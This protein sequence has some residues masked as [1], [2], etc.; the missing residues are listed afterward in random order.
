MRFIVQLIRRETL[1]KV[2]IIKASLVNENMGD[3]KNTIRKNVCAYCRVSTDNE[4]QQTSYASQ[5]EHYST[6]IKKNPNWNFAGIYADEGITGTQIKNRTEF[7]RMIEDAKAKKIDLII[8]KSIS[9]FARNTVDTLNT[10]RLLRSLNVDVF[11][12][13]E[14]IKTL[15]MDSEM[16]LTLYSAFAQAESESTSLNVRMGYQAKMKR[17]EACGSIKCYGYDYNKNTKILSINETEAKVV[18][19]IFDFY[20]NGLGSTRICNELMKCNIFS[21]MNAKKWHPSVIKG[22]LRNV[23][24]IGDVVGQKYFVISPITHKLVLNRG[25]RQKY[26]S[27]DHHDPI[28]DINTWNQAQNIYDKRSFAIKD[29]KQYCPKYSQRYIYSSMIECGICH[30]NYVRRVTS[31]RNKDGVKHT[32]VYWFCSAKTKREECENNI[33]VRETELNNMFI[34]LFNHLGK[35]LSIDG[36]FNKIDK[37]ISENNYESDLKQLLKEESAVNEKALKL[38]DLKL[39][40]NLDD[41]LYKIKNKELL[42]QLSDIRIKKDEITKKIN[43]SKKQQNRLKMIEKEIIKSNG[44]V[45]FDEEIFKKVVKRVIIGE[46]MP[47]GTK[48]YNTIKFVLN[49]SGD[50]KYDFFSK[51]FLLL[52]PSKGIHATS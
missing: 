5:I 8:S 29:G 11:F 19:K 34:K 36:I 12:E 50:M 6:M 47:D 18:R 1:G 23:K 17:G 52:E 24:Y 27:R 45:N 3:H 41:D 13:K 20:I 4:E 28:I 26:Y 40:D 10:V 44:M 16:F 2:E 22:I 31:Y 14:N 43:D 21:P 48:N 32:Y 49:V 37:I 42:I 39:S 15:S 38:I 25:Q 30:N 9:R 7:K 46:I 51:K 33:T 35:N